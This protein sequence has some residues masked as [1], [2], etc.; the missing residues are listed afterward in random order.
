MLKEKIPC[1]R[2]SMR[3]LQAGRLA[4]LDA[5]E[6][7]VLLRSTEQDRRCQNTGKK[8]KAQTDDTG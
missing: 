8:K 7:V 1:L 3:N 5:P 4:I 2:M 6:I